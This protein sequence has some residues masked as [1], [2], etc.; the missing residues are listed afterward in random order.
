MR[1]A[2]V[3][4]AQR[5]FSGNLKRLERQGRASVTYRTT[6]RQRRHNKAQGGESRAADIEKVTFS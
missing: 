4:K 2:L 3:E 6:K 5:Y 1:T